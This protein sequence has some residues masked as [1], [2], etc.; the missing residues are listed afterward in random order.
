MAKVPFNPG[1]SGVS[2]MIQRP[3]DTS[4]LLAA[5]DMQDSLRQSGPKMPQGPERPALTNKKVRKLKV[6]K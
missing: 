4:L 3:S 5:A 1:A 2:P 6:V